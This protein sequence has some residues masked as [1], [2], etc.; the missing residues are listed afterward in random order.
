[1]GVVNTFILYRFFASDGRLLYVGMTRNP[2]QRFDNHSS[3]KP[4]WSEVGRIEIEHY[5]TLEDL[6]EAERL[7][8]QTDKPLHN[9]RMNGNSA[10]SRAPQEEDFT[11]KFEPS[12]RIG[13]RVGVVYA[14][15]LSN[16]ECPVGMVR[17]FDDIGVTLIPFNWIWGGFD[18]PDTWVRQSDVRCWLRAEKERLTHGERASDGFFYPPTVKEL[19]LMDPLADFQ[20]K[21]TAEAVPA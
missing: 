16:G 9:V 3:D 17:E 20:T 18:G 12:S 1:M 4:W 6:R 15:G 10:Q 19:W 21:W 11:V 8:I 13:L 2:A 5:P 14:I 7:A